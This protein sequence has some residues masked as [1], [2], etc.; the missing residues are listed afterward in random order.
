[1]IAPLQ[2]TADRVGR[3]VEEFARCLDKFNTA[4]ASTDQK[5]WDDACVLLDEYNSITT[6]RRDRIRSSSPK[7]R[8]SSRSIK[9]LDET[10][11]EADRVRWEADLWALAHDKILT[12]SPTAVDDADAAC[13]QAFVVLNQYSP[14]AD[15]WSSFLNS[16]LIAQEYEAQLAWLQLRVTFGHLEQEMQDL[17]APLLAKADR[18]DGVWSS[19]AIYTKTAIKAQKRVRSWTEPLHPSNPGLRNVHKRATDGLPLVAQLDPDAS[20]REAAVL[21]PQD[22]FHEQASWQA[23][24]EFLRRGVSQA[25]I[26][27]YW[28][29]RKESWRFG[30]LRAND[31]FMNRSSDLDK[32]PW[33]RIMNIA[34]NEHWY[35]TC[36]QLAQMTDDNYEYQTAVYGVLSGSLDP[37][38]TVCKTIDDS[39]FA[40]FNT[41]LIS[42]YREFLSSYQTYLAN[43]QHNFFTPRIADSSLAQ[44]YL[45]QIKTN[46]KT[47]EESRDPFILIE[48]ALLSNNIHDLFLQLGIASGQVAHT[49]GGM[50]H[51]MNGDPDAPKNEVA[52]LAALNP[53]CVRIVAHLQ[54]LYKSLGYLEEPYQNSLYQIENNIVNFMGWL[55]RDGKL[56]LMPLY[57]S[58][59]SEKRIPYVLGPILLEVVD[60]RERDQQV[61]LMKQNN[62]NVSDTIYGI[63]SFANTVKLFDF[64]RGKTPF[65][66]SRITQ[67]VKAGGNKFRTPK[68]LPDFM[69]D[70]VEDNDGKGIRSVEWYRYIDADNWGKACYSIGTLYKIFL[71]QGKLAA[72]KELAQR[73]SL[74][75]ISL[76][77]LGINAHFADM[78]S[79]SEENGVFGIDGSLS[80]ERTK[81][82]SPSKRRKEKEHPLTKPSTTREVAASQAN[83]WSHLEQ[84]VLAM[85]ALEDWTTLAADI[86][87]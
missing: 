12:G 65:T 27:E 59:L 30:I 51:L 36:Q 2:E 54:L 18:G 61:R 6:T 63:F 79:P 8:S 16:D 44:K 28:S 26:E 39:L 81:S 31:A 74:T 5:L 15:I 14:N 1:M 3:Q 53:D 56:N 82:L 87:R 9:S 11:A 77:A 33:L 17:I 42:R 60:L 7:A 73:A 70:Q 58:K 21:E 23:C 41:L 22:D 67:L 75:E 69:G 71:F 25:D 78:M 86:E 84:L 76:A 46:E 57:A 85:I 38:L 43:P 37:S 4:R 80:E 66:A 35:L 52:H 10:T 29:T 49:T 64:K 48:T 13:Q 20:T 72:A 50:K 34:T 68:L 24:W 47:K 19:T 32:S 83:V 55:E 45:A 40:I 62:I